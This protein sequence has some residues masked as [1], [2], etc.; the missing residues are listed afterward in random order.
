MHIVWLQ[1]CAV[2][3]VQSV[4]SVFHSCEKN[5]KVRREWVGLEKT[6]EDLEL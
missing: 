1:I 2:S 4:K 5:D 6:V 3:C